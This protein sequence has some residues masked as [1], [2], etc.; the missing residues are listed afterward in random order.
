MVPSHF[1]MVIPF[2]HSNDKRILILVKLEHLLIFFCSIG[3]RIQTI[4]YFSA[5]CRQ[6]DMQ[7]NSRK[8]L[9]FLLLCFHSLLVTLYSL[10][11]P[12]LN[13]LPFHHFYNTI[14]DVLIYH[15]YDL[16]FVDLIF[17]TIQI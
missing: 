17:G 9:N 7:K 14:H 4:E 6:I 13:Q 11:A 16:K 3:G 2:L 15:R 12:V 10:I 1:Q 8:A 5:K